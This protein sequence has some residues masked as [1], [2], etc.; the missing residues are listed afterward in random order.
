LNAKELSDQQV[1]DIVARWQGLVLL[2]DMYLHP[3]IHRAY[4]KSPFLYMYLY[5][6]LPVQFSDALREEQDL[7]VQEEFLKHSRIS[8]AGD[9]DNI[10][11][12][13]YR[14]S[15]ISERFYMALTG[16]W[17]ICEAMRFAKI[18]RYPLQ[19]E[20]NKI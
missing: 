4:S 2:R 12:G 18:C 1:W 15:S 10:L 8:A 20:E 13:Y 19:T 3:S 16:Y 11:I 7:D 9:Q 5:G 6:D 17:L 14:D